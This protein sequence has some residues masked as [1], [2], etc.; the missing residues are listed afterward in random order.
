MKITFIICI[1][2]CVVCGN[3]EDFRVIDSIIQEKPCASLGGICTIA[4]DCPKGH[5]AE[6]KDLC[7]TQRKQGIECCHG[8][9]IKELRCEKN[10]GTCIKQSDYCNP[11]LVFDA[12]DCPSDRKCCILV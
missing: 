9:S 3:E 6:K 11:K 2:V 8:L 5:L 12:I 7:P 1:F 4:A 10:G